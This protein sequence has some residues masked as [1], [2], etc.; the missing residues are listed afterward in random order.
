MLITLITDKEIR[1]L[2]SR[3]KEMC[4]KVFESFKTEKGVILKYFCSF[5]LSK[6]GMQTCSEMYTWQKPINCDWDKHIRFTYNN[7]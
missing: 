7:N 5:R 4:E 1:Q 6:N 3:C 2:P